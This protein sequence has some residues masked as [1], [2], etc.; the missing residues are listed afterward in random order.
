MDFFND[1]CFLSNSRIKTINAMVVHRVTKKIAAY[2]CFILIFTAPALCYSSI[3]TEY[4]GGLLKIK[5]GSE[6]LR[7]GI[8]SYLN[9]NVTGRI[10][11]SYTKT[12]VIN[13]YS[14][15]FE[16]GHITVHFEYNAKKRDSMARPHWLGGGSVIGPWTSAS[17]WIEIDLE[18]YVKDGI[19]FLHSYSDSIRW[20]K[21]TWFTNAIMGELF[22]N[23]I[24]ERIISG[25]NEG[26]L[27]RLGKRILDVNDLVISYGAPEVARKT[28]RNESNTYE[29]I[30]DALL[31]H[32]PKVFIDKEGIHIH[33]GLK[34]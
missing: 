33:L 6:D 2:L 24:A 26:I 12:A 29:L 4:K 11:D 18:P 25:V 7:P 27:S 14:T 22:E 17:G 3:D 8:N 1:T 15:V 20:D 34:Y 10:M 23:V 16:D 30:T 31:K 19:L 28:G 5:I 13:K 9:K 32:K 21:K